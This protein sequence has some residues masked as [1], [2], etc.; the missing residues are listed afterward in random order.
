MGHR[1]SPQA[2]QGESLIFFF[3]L[4]NNNKI[5]ADSAHRILKK[6]CKR[7]IM[8][9]C[10]FVGKKKCASVVVTGGQHNMNNEQFNK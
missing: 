4:E 7:I 1:G 3:F 8:S 9:N 2:D 6:K 10:V 5:D